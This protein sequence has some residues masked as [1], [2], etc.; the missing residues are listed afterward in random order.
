MKI[1]D[2]NFLNYKN[3]NGGNQDIGEDYDKYLLNK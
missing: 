3:K 1:K 2:L